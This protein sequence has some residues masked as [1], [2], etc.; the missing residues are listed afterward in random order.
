MRDRG[1]DRGRCERVEVVVARRELTVEKA[2][3]DTARCLSRQVSASQIHVARTQHE[4]RFLCKHDRASHL[5]FP[6]FP[7]P[8]EEL[9]D[10]SED[11]WIRHF[12]FSEL[13]KKKSTT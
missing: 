5:W 1:E 4:P 11:G 10:F 7:L 3:H 2:R 13:Q 12:F 8:G 6:R 9:F